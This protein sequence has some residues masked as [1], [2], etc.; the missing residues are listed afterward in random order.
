MKTQGEGILYSMVY[1]CRKKKRKKKEKYPKGWLHYLK[2][3]KY[4]KK[5]KN[6]LYEEYKER[7]KQLDA[8]YKNKGKKKNLTKEKKEKSDISR[9]IGERKILRFLKKYRIEYIE[10]KIFRDCINPKTDCQLRF[11]FYLPKHNICIEYDGEQHFKYVAEFDKGD[12]QKLKERQNRDK[13][14][15][16]YCEE[17]GIVLVRIKYN[18]INTIN[19]VLKRVLKIDE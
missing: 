16:K 18:R 15:N 17:R 11:D 1:E 19:Q 8:P 9:S 6:R 13:F 4:T 5:L 14:K 10:E 2:K 3:I 7:Q 12:L